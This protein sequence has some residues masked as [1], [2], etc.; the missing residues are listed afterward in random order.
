MI[1]SKNRNDVSQTWSP[2]YSIMVMV[3]GVSYG[4]DINGTNIPR[5]VRTLREARLQTCSGHCSSMMA[6]M[7]FT[8]RLCCV[9]WLAVSEVT[10]SVLQ[11]WNG[12]EVKGMG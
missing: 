7:S 12:E 6:M 4:Q 9:E 5:Q 3:P 1:N 10:R 8:G 11:I 2:I